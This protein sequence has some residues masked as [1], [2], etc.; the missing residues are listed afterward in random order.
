MS[1]KLETYQRADGWWSFRI[2]GQESHYRSSNEEGLQRTINL[3]LTGK[4]P[5]R[6]NVSAVRAASKTLVNASESPGGEPEDWTSLPTVN[7]R[8]TAFMRRG[9]LGAAQQPLVKPTEEVAE[10]QE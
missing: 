7:E 4:G 3:L 2:N 6:I 8:V 9:K 1:Y 10:S 5:R